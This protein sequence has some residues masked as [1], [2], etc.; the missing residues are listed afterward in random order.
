ML[1]TSEAGSGAQAC[2][3]TLAWQT[4]QVLSKAMLPF[5]TNCGSLN[6]T[7]RALHPSSSRTHLR[8]NPRGKFV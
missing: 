5:S 7:A 4:Q 1:P 6:S 2:D 3:T 8:I